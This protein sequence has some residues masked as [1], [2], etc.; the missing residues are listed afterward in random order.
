[1][2]SGAKGLIDDAYALRPSWDMVTGVLGGAK[3][4]NRGHFRGN[5]SWWTLRSAGT[6]LGVNVTPQCD[7]DRSPV[8]T[9]LT[10]GKD[11]LW[12]P[13]VKQ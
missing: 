12:F 7:T 5:R 8:T 3:G 1:M 9:N 4:V 10:C 2:G 13:Q 11:V 6:G